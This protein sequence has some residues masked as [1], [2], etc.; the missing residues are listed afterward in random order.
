MGRGDTFLIQSNSLN[1][2]TN[3]RHRAY[4]EDPFFKK[5]HKEVWHV[6]GKGRDIRISRLYRN[7][8]CGHDGGD[9]DGSGSS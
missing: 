8:K 4:Y 2:T 5:K 7:E 1:L 9:D 6:R 3:L